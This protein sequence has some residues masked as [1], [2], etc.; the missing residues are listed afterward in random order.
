MVSSATI[1]AGDHN[2]L[3]STTSLDDTEQRNKQYR[4]PVQR[5]LVSL[6]DTMHISK[7]VRSMQSQF[8]RSRRWIR[9]V[10]STPSCHAIPRRRR[11]ISMQTRL[12]LPRRLLF[13]VRSE[14]PDWCDL[15][16]CPMSPTFS[17][18]SQYQGGMPLWLS[19]IFQSTWLKTSFTNQS[20][21]G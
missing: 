6:K 2:K 16:R 17:N 8:D 11:K 20:N 9:S 12:H 4:K 3:Q 13:D 10:T 1:V 19:Q 14:P 5:Q 18:R 21:G 7:P 15:H